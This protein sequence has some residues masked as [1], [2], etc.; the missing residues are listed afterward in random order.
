MTMA[1]QIVQ[2]ATVPV[3]VI[4]GFLGAGK[5]TL[6]NRILKAGGRRYAVLVNDFGSVNV[7]AALIESEDGLTKQLGNGC[8][9]CSMSAGV[10]PA[11]DAAMQSNPEAVIIEGSG[12]GDPWRIA[13][14]AIIDRRLSLEL[15][16]TLVD[17]ANFTRQLRDDMLSDTLERQLARADLVVVNKIDLASAAQ[18]AA[19]DAAVRH[20]RPD[21]RIVHTQESALPDELIGGLIVAGDRAGGPAVV[22]DHTADCAC[23][24]PH[25]HLHNDPHHESQFARWLTPAPGALDRAAFESRLNELPATVLRLKGWVRF[26]EGQ[27]VCLVQYTAGRFRISSANDHLTETVLVG[28]GLRDA[29]V[30]PALAALVAA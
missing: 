9:C 18:I 13:E 11:L 8:I 25:D 23:G 17:A 28:I 3:M 29:G 30:E 5:T 4:G 26:R 22:H 19:V 7:D 14:L 20:I 16:V 27:G 2:D 6:L 21:V 10:G 15:V 12:V 1:Y 24:A